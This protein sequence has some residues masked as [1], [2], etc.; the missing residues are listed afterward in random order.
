MTLIV[1]GE[2]IDDSLIQQEVER[3]RPDY[4][5][6]FKDQKPQQQNKQLYQWS[7]ENVI[8]R[9]LLNQE[10]KR[11]GQPVPE[12]EIES[13]YAKLKQENEFPE[14]NEQQTREAVELQIR[15]ERLLKDISSKVPEPSE[16]QILNFYNKNRDQFKSAEQ[17]SVSHIVKHIDCQTDE[18]AARKIIKDAM[19]KIR[20]GASF[21]MLVEQY[22]DC[23][24]NGGWL[25][26]ITRG[27]MVE[28]FEDVVFKMGV[29]EVSEMFQTRFGF[30]IAKVY[31]R[32]KES[33][34]ELKEVRQHIKE[35]V[36]AQM[37]Q[38]NVE[39]FIDK[40]K[41]KASIYDV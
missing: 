1:N 22:S 9:V 27:Q 26:Y 5:R 24:Q 31:N 32:K 14:K 34:P 38:D 41:E 3:L 23:P 19:E 4:Q 15:V 29:G 28:E 8:E 11:H 2:H 18:E 6:V 33:I 17:V 40:L 21:E 20:K 35:K 30:H 12:E 16:E 37:N 10:A 36:K 13:A 25:G 39:T 7:R